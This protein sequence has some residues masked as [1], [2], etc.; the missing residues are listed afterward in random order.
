MIPKLSRAEWLTACIIGVVFVAHLL[1]IATPADK[2]VY[3][4]ALF[5]PAAKCMLRGLSCN[6]EHPPLGK[7]IVAGSIA[8]L[9]DNSIAWRLPSVLAGTLA[10]L[11]VFLIVRKYASEKTAMIAAFLLGVENL[12][13]TQSSLAMLDTIAVFF[14][15][16]AMLAF[17]HGRSVLTGTLLGIAMLTKESMALMLPVFVLH[18]AVMQKRAFSQK[19]LRA[20]VKA[21]LRVVLPALAVFLAGLWVYDA[22]FD[23]FPS[24]VHHLAYLSEY[25]RTYEPPSAGGAV[26]P[27]MWLFW[28][29]EITY[30]EDAP[31]VR[32][33]SR[34]NLLALVLFWLAVPYAWLRA[35]KK[36]SLAV[37]GLLGIVIPLAGFS[38]VAFSRATY[39]FYAVLFLPAVCMLSARFLEHQSRSVVLAVLA[40]VL[41]WFVLWFPVQLVLS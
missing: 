14:V 36:D 34:Q 17:V 11:L 24:P 8:L 41:A 33:A 38:L 25:H 29:K 4:E 18:A 31:K 6:P 30:Y 12:W 26:H 40:A 39:P 13:F 1:I 15:L 32:Y 2:Y 19:A 9:G 20:A 28:P 37:L 35:R 27:A 3:D 22:A 16:C 10:V 21:A 7:A 5:V 23:A